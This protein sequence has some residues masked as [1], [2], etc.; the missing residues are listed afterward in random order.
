MRAL[1]R[2]LL[3]LAAAL[4]VLGAATAGATPSIHSPLPG[5]PRLRGVIPVR[6]ST[7]GIE[8]RGRAIET[9]LRKLSPASSVDPAPNCTE[10]STNP[11]ANLCWWGG[12]VVRAYTA[13]LIFWQGTTPLPAKVEPFI[14][15][16]EARIEAYFRN[17]EQDDGSSSNTYSV[18]AQ[19]GDSEGSGAYALTSVDSYVDVKDELP[20]AGEESEKKCTD[21][22]AAKSVCIT[23]ANLHEEVENARKANPGWGVGLKNIYFVFTPPNVGGCF[24]AGSDTTG[25]SCAFSEN[26]AGYC[27]YHSDF[28]DAAKEPVL[29]ADMP[30]ASGIEGCDSFEYP[31]GVG[32][33]DAILDNASHENIETITDPLGEGWLDQIGQEVADKCLPPET[34]EIYGE[35]FGGTPATENESFEITPGT[36][37]NEVIGSQDYWLQTV[38]SNSAGEFQG[39]CEQRMVNAAFNIP[40]GAQAT[41]P[42]TF[43]GAPSGSPGDPVGYWVWGFGDGFQ[44]GTPQAT[45][46]HTY[47]EPG[48]YSVTLTAV[49]AQANTNTITHTV[50]VGVAPVPPSPP[51]PPAPIVETVTVTNTVTTP[52]P[53]KSATIPPCPSSSPHASKGCPATRRPAATP[54]RHRKCGSRATSRRG[55]RCPRSKKR[56]SKRSRH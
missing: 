51:T 7:P 28:E 9:A 18:A 41:A 3:C 11:G 21:S 44:V 34:F 1:R 25:D 50:T 31:E 55:R 15:E 38:W 26:G 53:A 46:S 30:D 12:P 54:T 56:S 39:G 29:Y 45:V 24:E 4:A 36:L 42:V 52:A 40:T 33:V 20:D 16:Y 2:Q 6:G 35:P 8:A 5:F 32:S 22:A 48:E 13:H 17:V 10:P 27:A 19:Y 49:D 43:S 47:A 23:D 37:F 14:H